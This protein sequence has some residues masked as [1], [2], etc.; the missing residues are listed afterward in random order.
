[1]R[2]FDQLRF[3]DAAGVQRL[4]ARVF[5]EQGAHFVK[6]ALSETAPSIREHLFGSMSPEQ[7][8]AVIESRVPEGISHDEIPAARWVIMEIAE[9]MEKAG[10]VDFS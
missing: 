3:L 6:L 8:R 4:V 5:S 10:E 7:R 2:S 1:M 9:S